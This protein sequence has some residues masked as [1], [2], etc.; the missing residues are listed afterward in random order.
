MR[1][2][3]STYSQLNLELSSGLAR[4]HGGLCCWRPAGGLQ[5]RIMAARTGG[6]QRTGCHSSR[7][8]YFDIVTTKRD[9]IRDMIEYQNVKDKSNSLRFVGPAFGMGTGRVPRH[10]DGVARRNGGHHQAAGLLLGKARKAIVCYFVERALLSQS[11]RSFHVP[12]GRHS[13]ASPV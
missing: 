12:V 7:S 5:A 11:A 2:Y 10:A 8:K 3:M 6:F 4:P 1:F 9:I 13:G